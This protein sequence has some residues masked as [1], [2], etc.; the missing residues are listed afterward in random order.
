M[1][2]TQIY[3]TQKER[4]NLI[5]LSQKLGQHQSA[6]IKEA[7]DQFIERKFNKKH[8]ILQASFGL[9]SER[10]DLPDFRKLR[11]EFYRF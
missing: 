9:W 2:R 4:E 10:D 8:R 11:E 5:I 1:F 6:L 7:I 3:L